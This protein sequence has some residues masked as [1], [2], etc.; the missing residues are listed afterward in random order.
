M[1][2]PRGLLD[3]IDEYVSDA[4]RATGTRPPPL[5]THA[6]L[7]EPSI[8]SSAD[9]EPTQP[10]ASNDFAEED[11]YAWQLPA[12][13]IDE[14]NADAALLAQVNRQL[15]MRDDPFAALPRIR[16]PRDS[17]PPLPELDLDDEVTAVVSKPL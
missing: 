7:P 17:S 11:S 8:E 6:A 3:M 1:E 9:P 10:D 14:D 5:R 16:A 4:R 13:V 12:I 2:L 15:A